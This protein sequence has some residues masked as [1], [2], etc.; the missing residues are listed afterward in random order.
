[1]YLTINVMNIYIGLAVCT[2]ST[3]VN[4]V[5][6]SLEIIFPLGFADLNNVL[7]PCFLLTRKNAV[8]SI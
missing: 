7:D 2:V 3:L 6:S 1:M 5:W 4:Q 8:L